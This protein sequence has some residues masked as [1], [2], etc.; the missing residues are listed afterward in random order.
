M[1]SDTGVRAVPMPGVPPEAADRASRHAS[2]TLGLTLPGD[3]VLYLL[4]PLY[5]DG[6]GVTLPEAG[7]L[8]AA[9]RLVR[10]AGYGWVARGYERFGPR[11]AC[12]AA[13]L[14]ATGATLGYAVL[15]GVGLLLLTRLMWGL[16]FA[17]LNIATQAQATSEAH[18]ASSRSGRSRAIIAAGPMLGLLGAAALTETV[19]PRAVFLALACVAVLALPFA[20]RLPGGPG[21]RLRV[22]GRRLRPPS[23]LDLWSFI[24]GLTL[25]GIFVIGLA[26]LASAAS[27]DSAVVAAGCALALRYVA[28]IALGPVSG[29]IAERCGAA[30]SLIVLSL[31]SAVAYAA[32]SIG[33]L[34]AGV[35]AVL[36]LRG[37]LA[38]LAAPVAALANPGGQRVP[39]IAR[40]A[41]WRDLGA[42]IGPLLAGLLLPIAPFGLYA[43]AAA[44][45]AAATLALAILDL[46][47]WRRR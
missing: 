40:M 21:Q 8:L 2:L 43:A 37:M 47:A 6:F 41:T 16:S 46:G 32:I 20:A 13:T 4:L 44:A 10:I 17:A 3:T 15:S 23:P 35:I 11:A 9:N 27:P 18:R 34:W 12:V 29:A 24:Q 42:G 19:G 38:P 25:D 7:L 45:L 5:A 36:L 30:R 33:I 31:A 28:E 26:V 22:G 1:T 39:A 14:G